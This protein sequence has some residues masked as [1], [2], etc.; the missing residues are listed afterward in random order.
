MHER[1]AYIRVPVGI[2]A[3]YQLA[4]NLSAPRFGM[5]QDVSLGG[6]RFTP[7]DPLQPGDKVSVTLALPR[8]G[9]V[10]LA[11]VVVWARESHDGRSRYEAGLRWTEVNPAAQARLNAFL[12]EHTRS[13]DVVASAPPEV[14]DVI[15]WP[16]VLAVSIAIFAL[17][18][19]FTRAWISHR[20]LTEE[21]S[22]LRNTVQAYQ[23]QLDASR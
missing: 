2:E 14:P 21:V 10:I 5:S 3:S 15:S 4:R 9:D 18:V 17:M 16:K 6:M 1:R 19:I 8:E 23:Y 20:V 7:S 12:T 11:G 13:Y 22:S